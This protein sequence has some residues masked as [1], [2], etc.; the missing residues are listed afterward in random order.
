MLFK[1]RKFISEMQNICKH[2]LRNGTIFYLMVLKLKDSAENL[3]GTLYEEASV[4]LTHCL[5]CQIQI[6]AASELL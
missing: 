1:V 3:S 2:I 5:H 6:Q 4:L